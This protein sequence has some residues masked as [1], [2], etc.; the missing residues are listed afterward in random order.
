M[1]Q[2]LIL[3]QLISNTGKTKTFSKVTKSK[4]FSD[5]DFKQSNKIN[6][7]ETKTLSA[8]TKPKHR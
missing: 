6:T 2:L 7:G 3:S 8:V 4:H 1:Y 5:R